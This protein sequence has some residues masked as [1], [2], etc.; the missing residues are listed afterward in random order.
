VKRKEPARLMGSHFASNEKTCNN[1]GKR[2][3]LLGH[4]LKQ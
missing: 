1:M 3:A 2:E 4:D